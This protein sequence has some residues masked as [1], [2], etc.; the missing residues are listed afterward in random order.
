MIST[1][2]TLF[3]KTEV[4]R[5]EVTLMRARGALVNENRSDE[6]IGDVVDED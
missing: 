2:V 1:E 5:T 4:M 6:D 3:M